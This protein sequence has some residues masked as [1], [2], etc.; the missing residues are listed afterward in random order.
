MT[1]PSCLACFL[2]V[3]EWFARR[4]SVSLSRDACSSSGDG[5]LECQRLR[6]S[7]SLGNEIQL[8]LVLFSSGTHQP[9]A[10]GARNLL[11]LARK[12]REAIKTLPIQS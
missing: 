7:E 11:C 4:V 10:I 6:T 12:Y 5:T 1:G 3:P 2:A 8:G 9:C